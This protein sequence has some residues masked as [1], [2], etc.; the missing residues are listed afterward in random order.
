MVRQPRQQC[1]EHSR[2]DATVALAAQAGKRLLQ[3]VDEEDTW[4]HCVRDLERLPHVLLGL[5]DQAAHQAAH[6]EEE[7]RSS[8]LGAERLG[9]GTLAGAGNAEQ[10]NAPWLDRPARPQRAPAE[11]LEV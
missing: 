2:R 8:G 5:T 10:E 11:L 9:K 1:P 3:L 4:A 6:I 7:C